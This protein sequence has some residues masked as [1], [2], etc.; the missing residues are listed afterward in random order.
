MRALSSASRQAD[1]QLPISFYLGGGGSGRWGGG[2]RL[3]IG[4]DQLTWKPDRVLRFLTGEQ[5]I[6]HVGSRVTVVRARLL[7]PLFNTAVLVVGE[8]GYVRVLTWYGR[9]RKVLAALLA[10]GFELN[11]RRTWVTL[12]MGVAKRAAAK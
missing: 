2:G 11:V 6:Y 1:V 4:P 12:G 7:P 5:T 3:T 8:R 9:Y 10:A